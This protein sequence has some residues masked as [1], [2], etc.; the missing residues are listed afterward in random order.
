MCMMSFRE[1][2][3]MLDDAD[4]LGI[5]ERKFL[6]V[7]RNVRRE[8]QTRGAVLAIGARAGRWAPLARLGGVNLWDCYA[9]AAAMNAGA[10]ATAEHRPPATGHRVNVCT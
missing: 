9:E 5:L 1:F 3:T 6:A 7:Y 10:T 8:P 4:K 2:V